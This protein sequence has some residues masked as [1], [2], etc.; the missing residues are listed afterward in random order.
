MCLEAVQLFCL[1]QIIGVLGLLSKV[2]LLE[3]AAANRSSAPAP[4]HEAQSGLSQR[5]NSAN[6]CVWA[7]VIL[8]HVFPTPVSNCST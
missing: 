4:V 5:M 6:E 7:A 2:T 3:R 8:E 1:I